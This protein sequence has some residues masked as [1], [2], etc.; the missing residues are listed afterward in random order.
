MTTLTMQPICP[1]Q[2]LIM[3]LLIHELGQLDYICQDLPQ[4]DYTLTISKQNR[5]AKG[6]E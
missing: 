4:A 6:F 5:K 2:L 3:T 1:F